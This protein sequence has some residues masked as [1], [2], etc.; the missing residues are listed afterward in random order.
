MDAKPGAGSVQ[1]IEER[2][3]E[4]LKNVY[5]GGTEPELTF[6]SLMFG[7]IIGAIMCLSNLYVGFKAGWSLGVTITAAIMAFAIFRAFRTVFPFFV[8]RDMGML[9]TNILV[10]IASACAFIASAGLSNA[11]PALTM[12]SGRTLPTW[13]LGL[14]VAVILF[15][16]LFMAIPMKRQMI[17]VENLKF[18]TGFA[19]SEVLKGMYAEGGDAVK[20]ARALFA[21]LG[22]GLLIAWW[23]DGVIG[24]PKR[25]AGH[26]ARELGVLEWNRWLPA[27]PATLVP[28]SWSVFGMP[29]ARLTLS[30]EGSLIMV[31]AGAIMGIRAG[32]SLLLAALIGYGV[33]A[34]IYIAKGD[35]PHDPPSVQALCGFNQRPRVEAASDIA[36]PMAVEQGAAL[37]FSVLEAGKE[38]LILTKTWPQAEI[39]KNAAALEAELNGT[40]PFAGAIVF[41][42]DKGRN[43]LYAE[44]VRET[45]AETSLTVEQAALD[46]AAKARGR[47]LHFPVK[48]PP[49]A[50]LSFSAGEANGPTGPIAAEHL[51]VAFAQGAVFEDESAL[52]TFLNSEKLPDG[53]PNP[54]FGKISF[55]MQ[56]GRLA[57]SGA[58]FRRWDSRLSVDDCQA[59]PILGFQAGQNRSV[60]YGGFKN[61]VRWLMWP[62]VAMMV[63]AGLLSFFMQWRTVLRALS[64]LM[65]MFKKSSA[66]GSKDALAGVE[67]PGSWFAMGVLVTGVAAVI[68]QIWFFGIHWWMGIIAVAMSFFLA[69]VACRATGETDITPVGAMGKITQLMYGAIAPGNMTA[70]LMTANVTAGAATSSADLLQA[71]RCGH[72]V[73][74]SPRK[75]FLAML[76]GV[77]VGSA[78]AAPVYNI[79]VPAAD[80]LGTDKLPAPA[81]QTW[82]GVALLL[83]NGLHA[84]PVSAR[85][86]LLWGGLFGIA[87]TLCER[88]WPKS[89]KFLPSAT[90]MG[91]AFVIPAYNSV[92]MFIGAFIAWILDKRAP[93]FS[94]TYT[95]STASGLI[96][97]ES[98]MGIGVAILVA[99]QLM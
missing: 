74:A 32:I 37:S 6:R 5:K 98:L 96:A 94:E 12:V 1:E 84:L 11:V 46:F 38:P 33:L 76:L 41:G 86:G 42:V 39:F 54:F 72:Q 16:G 10:T 66:V 24:L 48:M 70:N 15:L 83:S 29:L 89:R 14:W 57:A 52:L 35:I 81:A 8:K 23:R 91:I 22:L 45:V 36:F 93:A 20:K 97:G 69:I 55:S 2:E 65:T 25:V 17:N 34:P 73:G 4:W 50:V 95:I 40:P 78:V 62:G 67:V 82:A 43:R 75:Q 28:S 99:F 58:G 59:A 51:A 44:L 27:I 88:L 47:A 61:I 13:Q 9:E 21:A 7:A 80:V 18:P 68:L 64:G 77:V 85:W 90:A 53:G 26:F 49:G 19:T 71:L 63:T 92:S 56:R 3:R 60:P 31:G 87:V 30:F 79:L